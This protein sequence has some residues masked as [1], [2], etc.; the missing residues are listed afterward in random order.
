MTADYNKLSINQRKF[1]DEQMTDFLGA[2]RVALTSATETIE[3]VRVLEW[4]CATGGN[5]VKLIAEL[6]QLV[7]KQ[8][9][10]QALLCDLP[11]NHWGEV[12]KA[13]AQM[14]D[15]ESNTFF[16]V[17]GRSFYEA[18]V[19]NSSVDFLYSFTSIHWTCQLVRLPVA[20]TYKEYETFLENEEGQAK[21]SFN[22]LVELALQSLKT[23]GVCFLNFPGLVGNFEDDLDF[24]QM[25]SLYAE[26]WKELL[27]LTNEELR[28]FYVC[29]Q[30]RRPYS[31]IDKCLKAFRQCKVQHAVIDK[32]LP[33][34]LATKDNAYTLASACV[35]A[36]YLHYISR[37]PRRTKSCLPEA[38]IVIED[39]AMR[40]LEFSKESGFLPQVKRITIIFQKCEVK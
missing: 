3:T 11:G 22:V 38:D 33:V 21:S 6:R 4:G 29:P 27:G 34:V 9:P 2:A 5:S 13:M 40:L 1:I 23:G 17:I 10:I 14:C 32:N 8:R 30:A 16:A 12:F 24:L 36:T 39:F 25:Q 19:P 28:E 35:T 37:A 15:K 31:M 7:S 26:T 20:A 18:V